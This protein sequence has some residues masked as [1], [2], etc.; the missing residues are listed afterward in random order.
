MQK[1]GLSA[2]PSTHST[3]HT[4]CCMNSCCSMR[5]IIQQQLMF[6]KALAVRTR[7]RQDSPAAATTLSQAGSHTHTQTCTRCFYVHSQLQAAR[8]KA[9]HIHQNG[10]NCPCVLCAVHA[11]TDTHNS[12]LRTV[13]LL[14]PWWEASPPVKNKP[15]PPDGCI[16]SRCLSLGESNEAERR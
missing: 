6:A 1:K 12:P 14:Q 9:Q 15:P 5:R 8:N 11:H 13:L 2:Q 4:G 3:L 10:Q 7:A 16:K